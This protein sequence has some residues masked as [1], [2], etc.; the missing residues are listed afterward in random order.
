MYFYDINNKGFL[1]SEINEIPNGAIALTDEQYQQLFEAVSNGYQIRVDGTNITLI[2]PQPTAYHTL[3][4]GEW[5]LSD[6]A[7]KQKRADLLNQ[8][9]TSIDNTAALISAQWTR[10]TEEYK[11]REAAALV[12]KQHNYKGEA[13]IY[14]TGFSSAAGIDNKTAT[15][16]ILRQADGL[17]QLQAALSVQRMRKYELKKEGLSE[18]DLQSIHDDIIHQMRQLAEAY[19]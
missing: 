2:A 19:E 14:I 1:H 6:D 5:V 4:N 11:E 10:F 3:E 9:I 16:L 17:R 15:D 18:A 8:L 7:K 12:Y 13:G